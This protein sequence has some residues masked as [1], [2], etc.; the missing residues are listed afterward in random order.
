M[1][2]P[3]AS[4]LQT[5]LKSSR[6]WFVIPLLAICALLLYLAKLTES[7]FLLNV[8]TIPLE[9]IVGAVLVDAYMARKEREKRGRQ[10]MFIK[11]VIFRSE[12]RSLYLANFAALEQPPITMSMIRA[13]DL[14]QLKQFRE[15]AGTIR[16][17]SPEAMETVITQY[18]DAYPVFY[19]FMEWAIANDFERIFEE[20]VFVLHFIHDVKVF[21]AQHPGQMFIDHARHD[22]AMM[23]KVMR[24]LGTG[25][26]KFLEYVIELKSSQPAT[27]D[28]LLAD[29]E[30]SARVP[31]TAYQGH[32][33][34]GKGRMLFQAMMKN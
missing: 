33:F 16:Y 25:I 17:R 28:G 24:I 34:L 27:F 14:A 31:A 10:L 21:K 4:V 12:L 22:P 9:M 11:S 23:D 8:A 15:S 13:A 2:S 7:A 19:G 29:Y 20:M 18:V 32:S 6:F 3:S 26:G 1:S 5:T 30:A